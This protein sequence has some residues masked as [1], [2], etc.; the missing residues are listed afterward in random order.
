MQ[1]IAKA[2]GIREQYIA[3]PGYVLCSCD[4]S[5]QEL[6]VLAQICHTRY[7]VS[8]LRDLINHHIDVHAYMA[9]V[10]DNQFRRLPEFNVDDSEIVEIYQ[11]TLTKFRHDD[12]DKFGE[13]RQLAKAANFGKVLTCKG[14]GRSK[15][16]EKIGEPLRRAIRPEGRQGWW[17]GA[18]TTGRGR[19]PISQHEA[20]TGHH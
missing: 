15:I 17:P 10:L 14:L 18:T 2:P 19:P 9:G 11:S 13:Y 1:N 3:P 16:S 5:Q 8:R 7:G 12:P 20:E 4:Y 6:V